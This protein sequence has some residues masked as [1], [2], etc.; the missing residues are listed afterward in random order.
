MDRNRSRSWR[1]LVPVLLTA[2][3][4]GVCSWRSLAG[5]TA[6]DC[7]ASARTDAVSVHC[8]DT[9]LKQLEAALHRAGARVTMSYPASLAHAPLSVAVDGLPLNLALAAALSSFNYATV[10]S[11][12]GGH[13]LLNV[14]I[15][16]LRSSGESVGAPQASATPKP[17]GPQSAP[18]DPRVP[19][20]VA[21]ETSAAAGPNAE[22]IAV[23]QPAESLQ[24]TM[25]TTTEQNSLAAVQAVESLRQTRSNTTAGP[26]LPIADTSAIDSLQET[27]PAASPPA[28]APAG[29]LNNPM[30]PAQLPKH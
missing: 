28:P 29:G 25:P 24:Q 7:T 1:T 23:R 4:A 30:V 15:F 17:V 20:M 14:E 12:D 9:T 3:V 5:E 18:F 13:P 10:N 27:T 22:A 2:A 16:S 21:V 26:P 19:P 11:G 6:H 8:S